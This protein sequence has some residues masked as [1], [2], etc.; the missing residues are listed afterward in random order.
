M[1][2]LASVALER[3][4]VRPLSQIEVPKTGRDYVR[5]RAG[6]G[7]W[8]EML[9]SGQK[10]VEGLGPTTSAGVLHKSSP[11]STNSE[12]SR[13]PVLLRV[14]GSYNDYERSGAG[15]TAERGAIL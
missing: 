5:P 11:S 2:E 4:A 9:V 8:F 7:L 14:R 1:A 15:V 13:G 12:D 6:P 10:A 3:L